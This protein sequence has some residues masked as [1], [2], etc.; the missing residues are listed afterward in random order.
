MFDSL[1][2]KIRE[3]DQKESNSTERIIRWVI[4]AV[5]SVVV[6]GGIYWGIHAL[7]G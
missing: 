4:I 1:A 6:F 2:D 3:D 5:V 7:Q